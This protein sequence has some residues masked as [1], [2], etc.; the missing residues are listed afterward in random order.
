MSTLAELF[1]TMMTNG[2]V[3]SYVKM[4]LVTPTSQ[5]R[6][7][8]ST[9]ADSNHLS[10]REATSWPPQNQ[11]VYIKKHDPE[12]EDSLQAWPLCDL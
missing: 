9:F 2:Y 7:M 5:G 4:D 6:M 11:A 8:L 3:P 1:K 12:C 10:P